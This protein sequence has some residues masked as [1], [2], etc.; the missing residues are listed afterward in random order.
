MRRFLELIGIGAAGVTATVMVIILWVTVALGPML[1]LIW[2]GA[3]IVK[4]VMG[5]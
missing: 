5:W 3:K 2:L 1:L 4:H